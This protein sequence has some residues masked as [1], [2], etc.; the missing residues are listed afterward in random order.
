[1]ANCSVPVCLKSRHCA[2][3]FDCRSRVRSLSFAVALLLVCAAPAFPA[4]MTFTDHAVTIS[5][6]TPSGQVALCGVVLEPLGYDSRIV[7]V[8]KIVTADAVG[9]ISY[10]TATSIDRSVWTAVDLTS[11]ALAK[12]A[13]KR[14]R[15][16]IIDSLTEAQPLRVGM[17]KFA[18]PSAFLIVMLVRP[19]TGV[20]ILNAGD[21]GP[22][23][24]DGTSDA[25][26]TISL[27]RLQP[28]SSGLPVLSALAPGDAVIAIDPYTLRAYTA[29]LPQL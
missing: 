6:L 9:T 4:D 22:D 25:R 14:S 23:D 7:R 29:R 13:S 8:A 27:K 2:I 12:G 20:W 11:G 19:G 17:I 10:T 26:V 5:G 24:D 15:A 1:M 3:R 18:R 21:G 28:L 16:E